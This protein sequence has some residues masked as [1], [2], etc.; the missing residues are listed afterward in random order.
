MEIEKLI[1]AARGEEPA[2]LLLKNARL[3]NV[4]SGE[5]HAADVAVAGGQVLGWGAYEARE[6]VDVEGR[7]LCPGFLDA[8]VHLES[9]MVRPAE[10]ARAVVPR[11]TTGV[12]TD[13]HEIANVLGLEGVRYMLQA[14]EGLP[15]RVYVMAPSCVPA[16]TMETAG[17]E[18]TAADIE[19]L[20][21][22]E[23]VIGLA[24]MMNFPG[25]LYRVPEVLA[26]LRAA[27]G[28]PIDGHAPGLGGLD[29]NAYVAA[30]VRSDHETTELE[31]AREKLR[32][33]MHLMI[34]EGTT[35]RNLEALLPVV[36]PA[37]AGMCHFCT[38]D[39]HPDTLLTEGGVDDVVRKAI[40]RGLDPVT[41]IQMATINTARYFRRWDMG[42]VA[43]GLQADL[44]VLDDL[45]GLRAWR[46]YAGGRLVAKEGRYLA[47]TAEGAP[48][49]VPRSMN[50][51]PAA[52]DFTIRSGK[53]PAR[54]IGIIPE[55]IVTEDLR[56]EP[57]VVDGVVVAD[58]ARDLI[59]M[60][61]VERHRGTGRAGLGLVRGLGL[62]SG[63]LASSVAH[64][65]HNVV[66]AGAGDDDMR[67]ALAAVVEMGGGQVVVDGGRVLAAC[68][69]PIAGL[70]SDR[71]LPEVRDQVAAL[72]EAAR[73]LG[74]SLPDPLM[75]MSFLAL[76]VIPALKLTD[77]GLVDVTRFDFVPL[78]EG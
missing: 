58:P 52:V 76:P 29:L 22:H 17:A 61:V 13:P 63:A 10:F 18:L 36:T 64:D 14:S 19:A 49:P 4:L 66:V 2:D 5:I 51:D 32:R 33:G 54:V 38:D 6:V 24:E 20:W 46:V 34:R 74:S 56:L 11:G 28:R 44:V 30:G 60:A 71:P 65:S 68:P 40:A 42:A 69:L 72:T 7:F 50:V 12:F 75:T 39:R 55:Q 26:K 78:F 43:P 25:V 67:A 59:K 45:E 77:R 73:G 57:T 31:E 21:A 15:L 1:A 62:R 53:G 41:A 48:V 23:R 35:A 47:A 70:M 3:V 37:N 27:A 8:H 16:T 9:A